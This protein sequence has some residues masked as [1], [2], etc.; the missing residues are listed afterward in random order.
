MS[1]TTSLKPFL[2]VFIFILVIIG[3]YII[4]QGILNPSDKVSG[5]TNQKPIVGSVAPDFVI[6]DVYGSQIP[7]SFVYE[8]RPVLLIFWSSWCPYC[9]QEL[10]DLLTFGSTYKGEIQVILIM[11]GE[12][13]QVVEK[14]ISDKNIPFLS[15]LDTD[16]VLW[17]LYEVSGTP[18]HFLIDTAGEIITTHPGM[19]LYP[20]LEDLTRYFIRR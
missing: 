17:Q 19:L 6:K 5:S 20:R 2:P 9:A 14:Y 18:S 15:S 13:K 1:K 12:N 16:R 7:L 8:K 3:I 11:S 4:G 10:P